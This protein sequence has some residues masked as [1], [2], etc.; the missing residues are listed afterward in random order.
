[1]R[2]MAAAL[3]LVMVSVACGGGDESVPD[4]TNVI[5]VE[6]RDF[7]FDRDV[8]EVRAGT[9]IVLEFRNLGSLEH[10]WTLLQAE[11]VI[12]TAAD[13]VDG[14]VLAE[15]KAD[16]AQAKTVVFVA[17]GTGTYQVVCAI[18]GHFEAGMEAALRVFG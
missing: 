6:A 11:L 9:E 8:I 12:S 2:R 1:M 3:L 7:E 14:S 18:P 13:I 16:A 4:G 10:T 5:T 17:P 15:A